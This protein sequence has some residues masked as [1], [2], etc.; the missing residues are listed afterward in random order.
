[1]G[2]KDLR[3]GLRTVLL[4]E[5]PIVVPVTVDHFGEDGGTNRSGHLKRNGDPRKTAD[6]KRMHESGAQ[7]RIYEVSPMRWIPEM[8]GG[9]LTRQVFCAVDA[10]ESSVRFDADCH[11]AEMEYVLAKLV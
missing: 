5:P 6:W 11:E 4:Q 9:V 3:S 7:A 1:L 10:K 8:T 2:S